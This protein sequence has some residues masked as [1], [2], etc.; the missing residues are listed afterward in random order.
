MCMKP[1]CMYLL[2]RVL[3]AYAGGVV[4]NQASDHSQCLNVVI[5]YKIHHYCED[6]C[7]SNCT[8]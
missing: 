8:L 4:L 5:H 1:Q 2:T 6:A 7:K 3:L